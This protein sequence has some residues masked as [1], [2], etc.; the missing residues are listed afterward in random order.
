MLC[1]NPR[2]GG[3]ARVDQGCKYQPDIMSC[4]LAGTSA[5]HALSIKNAS[6]LYMCR[7][8][9]VE[10]AA[11]YLGLSTFSSTSAEKGMMDQIMA[12][13]GQLRFE[14]LCPDPACLDSHHSNT[15]V[16]SYMPSCQLI[17]EFWASAW[18]SSACSIPVAICCPGKCCGSQIETFFWVGRSDG[19]CSLLS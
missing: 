8:M 19:V 17:P 14:L 16:T 10:C 7:C 9:S 5:N 4:C 12:T 15:A 1:M 6:V 3:P 18:T 13:Q 2:P 11:M